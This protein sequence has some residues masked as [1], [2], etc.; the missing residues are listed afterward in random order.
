MLFFLVTKRMKPK[1][2]LQVKISVL[3]EGIGKCLVFFG[4]GATGPKTYLEAVKNNKLN[5]ISK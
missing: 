2:S 4:L 3:L 1:L 5:S